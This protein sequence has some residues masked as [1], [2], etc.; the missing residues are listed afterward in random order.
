MNEEEVQKSDA[1]VSNQTENVL[2]RGEIIAD[3]I[4]NGFDMSKVNFIDIAQRKVWVHHTIYGTTAATATNYG[5]FYIVPVA[6][7][8]T[9]FQEV[10]QTAGSDGGAVTVMLEKLTG[11]QAPDAGVD[12]LTTAL[13]LKSTA[14]TVQTGVITNTYANRN[15]VAGDRLCL[16]DAGTLTSVANVTVV[17]ELQIK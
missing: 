4:H 17:V 8:L 2:G 11:T 16:E 7:V 9:K 6:C 13:S 3:H 5:V 14:N 12:M 15:L 1:E 10:H